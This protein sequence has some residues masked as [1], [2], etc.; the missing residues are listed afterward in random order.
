VNPKGF[1]TEGDDFFLWLADNGFLNKNFYIVCGDRHWQ[2]HS[3]HPS[4]FEEFSCGALVDANSRLGR[5]PGDPASTDPDA[6]LKQVYTQSEFSG[7]FLKITVRPDD[8]GGKPAAE[9]SF[10]DEWGVPLYSVSKSANQ[11]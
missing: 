3:I 2:Y 7:G 10:F 8:G 9:F 6:L 1:R 11:P 5:K 4:G